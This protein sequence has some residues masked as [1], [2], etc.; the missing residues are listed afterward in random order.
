MDFKQIQDLIKIVSKS[1]LSELKVEQDNFKITLRK[2]VSVP[3]GVNRQPG[4]QQQPAKTP[5]GIE[6]SLS[7]M[8]ITLPYWSP[9][10][11]IS[12]CRGSSISFST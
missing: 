2:Q 9:A 11:W 5:S 8:W 7:D 1:N 4:N 6:Q 10:T 3:G 12:I